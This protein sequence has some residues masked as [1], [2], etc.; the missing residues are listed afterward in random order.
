M[1]YLLDKY[2]SI[3]VAALLAY[4]SPIAT[5]M[6]FVGGLVMADFI[7]GIIKAHKSGVL[8]SRK[9][10]K[11]L[12][13]SASYLVVLMVVRACE[14][15]FNSELPLIEPMVAIIALSELKSLRENVEEITGNDPLKHLFGFLQ[16]KAES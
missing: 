6:L 12:Y 2:A 14:V 15:Y 1:Q 8:T 13:T 10:I 4:I 3:V 11:K 7:T 5:A 16:R 9:M